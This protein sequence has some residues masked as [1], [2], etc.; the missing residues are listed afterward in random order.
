MQRC[1]A[2][3]VRLV[4]GGTGTAGRAAR[5]GRGGAAEEP[6][7]VRAAALLKEAAADQRRGRGGGAR[8]DPAGRPGR[9]L[10]AVCDGR[11]RSSCS[12]GPRAGHDADTVTWSAAA[13]QRPPWP[14][15]RTA[16][17]VHPRPGDCVHRPAS[18]GRAGGRS[19]ASSR[20]RGTA[21]QLTSRPHV[22][23]TLLPPVSQLEAE[24]RTRP[25][26]RCTGP[27]IR[28]RSEVRVTRT[29][30]GGPPRSGAGDRKQLPGDRPDRG[31]GPAF[32]GHGRLPRTWTARR[33]C[34]ARRADQRH[35]AVGGAADP[36]A[37]DPAGRGRRARCA[38][39]C[40][41][42]RS[43]SPRCGSSGRTPRR[44]GSSGPGCHRSRCSSSGRR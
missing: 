15:R 9:S 19:T 11:H 35:S 20:S 18:A 25:R 27:R 26:S 16:R 5:G 1:R 40:P 21:A 17:S 10:R 28:P 37:A 34:A 39:G 2:E 38:S 32:R 12:G 29:A 22:A 4:D 13:E 23:V 8:G 44:R 33:C 31:P 42:C 6:D 30:P 43:T 36:E 3:A 14:R 7:E 24:R 41:G